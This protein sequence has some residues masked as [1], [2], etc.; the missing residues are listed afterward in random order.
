M[1]LAVRLAD[2]LSHYIHTY[3]G[4]TL[5]EIDAQK[6][7]LDPKPTRG[8]GMCKCS[9]AVKNNNLYWRFICGVSSVRSYECG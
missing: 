8:H 7:S 6:K 2:R 1:I 4:V 3:L 5:V 9:V